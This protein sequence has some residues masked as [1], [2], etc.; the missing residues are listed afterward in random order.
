MACPFRMLDFTEMISEVGG[1]EPTL[2]QPLV[3]PNSVLP[4]Y[5]PQVS[6]RGSRILPLNCPVVAVPLSAIVSRDRHGKYRVKFS[7]PENLRHSLLLQKDAKIIIT[8]VAPDRHVEDFWAEH[9]I[10]KVLLKIAELDVMAMT[11]PNFSFMSDVPRTNA[12]YNFARILRIAERMS[13]V[14]IATIL[15]LNASNSRDWERWFQVLKQQPGISHV[16]L[17]FQTGTGQTTI[18]DAYYHGLYTLQQKLGRQLHP[19]VLAGMGR[20]QAFKLHFKDSFTI[21][22]SMPFIKTL[23]R[24]SLIIAASGKGIWRRKLTPPGQYLDAEMASNLRTYE[25]LYQLGAHDHEGLL[26]AA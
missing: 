20:V 5:V 25:R 10:G 1:W 17:E 6:H 12:L 16:C 9:Q 19:V 13:E 2:S 26:F 18:G 4:S 7:S 21:I 8:S 15:H 11:A 3:T 14:G 22:D 23:K 24:R